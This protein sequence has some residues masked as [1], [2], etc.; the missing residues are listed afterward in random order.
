MKKILILALGKDSNPILKSLIDIKPDESY[1]LKGKELLPEQNLLIDNLSKDFIL[2]TID[3]FDYKDIFQKTFEIITKNK[4]D[5]IYLDVTTGTKSI[6]IGFMYASAFFDPRNV[7]LILRDIINNDKPYIYSDIKSLPK[8]SIMGLS[9]IQKEIVKI[10]TNQ[11]ESIKQIVKKVNPQLIIVK[12]KENNI[13]KME[14]L[15]EKKINYNLNILEKNNLVESSKENK[16][17]MFRLTFLGEKYKLI[18]L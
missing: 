11:H 5:I 2:K 15:K 12:S 1:L 8:P 9:K 17:M 16:E 7:K 13:E 3:P 6:L 10:L 14:F 18:N 4:K